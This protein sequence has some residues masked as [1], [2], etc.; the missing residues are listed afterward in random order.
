MTVY[1]LKPGESYFYVDT[2]CC[3]HELYAVDI[4]EDH[5]VLIDENRN[6]YYLEYHSEEYG[7][8]FVVAHRNQL[9]IFIF[10]NYDDAYK[11]SV[12]DNIIYLLNQLG[13]IDSYSLSYES[14][15][16]LEELQRRLEYALH[17]SWECEDED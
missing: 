11:Y 13:C 3:V 12:C 8:E 16:L 2:D 10:S 9:P 6:R 14:I 1:D 17:Y 5:E 7:V 15:T 4:I